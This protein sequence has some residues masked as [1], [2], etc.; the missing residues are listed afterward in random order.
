MAL[1]VETLKYTLYTTVTALN[2]SNKIS[3]RK[4]K[5]WTN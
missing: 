5:Q 4:S 3:I 2:Q 1:S